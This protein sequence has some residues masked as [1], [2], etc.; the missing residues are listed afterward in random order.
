MFRGVLPVGVLDA[1]ESRGRLLAAPG[2]RVSHSPHVLSASYP[3]TKFSLGLSFTC[4]SQSRPVRG[5]SGGSDE[6]PFFL[7]VQDPSPPLTECAANW[8]WRSAPPSRHA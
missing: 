5:S 1:I 6:P 7:L 8:P 4:D 2:V 3:L